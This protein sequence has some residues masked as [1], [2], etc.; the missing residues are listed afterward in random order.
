MGTRFFNIN[1]KKFFKDPS[2][3]L[4]YTFNWAEYL[5]DGETIDTQTITVPNGI[6]EDTTNANDTAVTVWLSGGTAGEDYDVVCRI[7]TSLGRIDE[8]TM[9]IQVREM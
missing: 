4:D 5:E 3:K 8:R 2:A 9:V 6:T 7:T 1:P